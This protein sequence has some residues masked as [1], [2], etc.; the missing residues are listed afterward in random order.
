MEQQIIAMTPR[1]LA[2]YEIIQRLLKKEINGTQAA[3]QLRLSVRQIKNIKARVIQEGP[4]GILHKGRGRTSNRKLP[5]D[6]TKA[7]L[8]IIQAK[9]PDFGP[10]F[11]SEK[12]WE[13]H[14]IAVNRETLRRLM[15]EQGLWQVKTRKKNNGYRSWRARKESFGQMEQFDGSYHHWFEQRGLECCLLASIDDATGKLT[16]LRF[17]KREGTIEAFSFWQDYLLK[18][19]K[20]LSIYLDRHSTYKQ[21]QKSVFDDPASLTQFERAMKQDLDIDVIHAYSPQA[22]GRAEKLFETLQDRLVKELRLAGISNLG[23]ANEFVEKVFLA[24]FNQRFSVAPTKKGNS[25]RTLTQW[26]KD[27]LDK[28]FSIKNQRFV[29]NDFTVKFKGQW[30]QLAQQQPVLV[31]QKEKVDIEERID[32]SWFIALRNKYLNYTLLPVRP[33][34]VKMKVHVISTSKPVWKPPANHPWR[35]PFVFNQQRY[36]APSLAN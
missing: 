18:H 4:R 23:K 34:K 33:A 27:N 31:R 3:E 9:Y 28:I 15:I 32:G 30:L 1:E 29:N 21:I 25:H 26:E 35:Q 24:R 12:L 11:A 7:I 6:R 20:P 14:Q 17:V 5:D 16:K 8:E 19:G 2:R 22:K 36:P 13:N 10:T